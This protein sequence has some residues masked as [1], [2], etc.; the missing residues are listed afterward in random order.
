MADVTVT[1]FPGVQ[2]ISGHVV[3][4]TGSIAIGNSI[5]IS[6]FPLT[7][8]IVGSVDINNFPA[9]QP[10]SVTN[11]PPTLLA[12]IINAPLAVT[13]TVD[14]LNFPAVLPVT[15][16]NFPA[17]Q[18]VSI[19]NPVTVANFPALQQV[20]VVNQPVTQIVS[21][22]VD[23][24]DR[25]GRTLG[26]VVVDS[27]GSVIVSNFPASYNIGN[28]PAVQAVTFAT[29]ARAAVLLSWERMPGVIADALTNFTN[30]TL[31]AVALPV[32]N[33]YTV[34]AGKTF[35]ITQINVALRTTAN[36]VVNT[37]VRIRQAA[38]VAN[39]SPIIWQ[40][41]LGASN[42]SNAAEVEYF[43]SYS[44]DGGID[45]SAGQQIAITHLESSAVGTVS[46]VVI[47]YEF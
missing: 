41:E 14:V 7:Y 45:V 10:V 24:T 42:T 12:T 6:N 43:Q 17:L 37:R 19:T 16:S 2:P 33:K 44:P 15:I 36:N 9:I 23:V 11:F 3:V 30:G 35:R 34:S 4:D 18:P 25:A 27:I 22:A 28:F 29:P 47:G 32:D 26:H 38:V 31:S 46:V 13:G 8:P 1:N 21:G 39:N 5:D 20:F 40:T